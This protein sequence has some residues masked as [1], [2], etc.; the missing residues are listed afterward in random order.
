MRHADIAVN[1]ISIAAAEFGGDFVLDCTKEKRIAVD[2]F[3]AHAGFRRYNRRSTAAVLEINPRLRQACSEISIA[4]IINRRYVG[5]LGFGKSLP[6]KK[7]DQM[8]S[9]EY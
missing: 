8:P 4:L 7:L 1:E 6:V 2:G 5:V 3:E 9:I